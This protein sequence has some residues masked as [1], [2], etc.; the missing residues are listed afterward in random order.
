MTSHPVEV[1]PGV[2]TLKQKLEGFDA[3]GSGVALGVCTAE[4]SEETIELMTEATE[5]A[6]GAVEDAVF[7]N[8]WILE[9]MSARI[10][11]SDLSMT[12]SCKIN[13]LSDCLRSSDLLV[14]GPLTAYALSSVAPAGMHPVADVKSR[15]PTGQFRA[16]LML[17]V[18][19]K[20][21]DI[22]DPEQ[23]TVPIVLMS[24]SM[25]PLASFVSVTVSSL[26]RVPGLCST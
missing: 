6:A 22:L 26:D 1:T 20:V 16:Q 4:L 11:G 15:V 21:M 7:T 23:E 24:S 12:S 9:M 19:V 10:D 3:G 17:S 13:S 2:M 18:L 14:A 25:M 8:C 5:V